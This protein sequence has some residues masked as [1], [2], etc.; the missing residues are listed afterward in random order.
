[1][2]ERS[3]CRNEE[4]LITSSPLPVK[5]SFFGI[6]HFF[7]ILN[8]ECPP[9]HLCCNFCTDLCQCLA[10]YCDMDLHLPIGTTEEEAQVRTISDEQMLSLKAELNAPK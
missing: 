8:L 1:M 7:G 5:D 6:Q 9:G 4:L 10:G 3:R 2:S